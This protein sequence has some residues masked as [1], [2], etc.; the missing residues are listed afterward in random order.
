MSLELGTKLAGLRIRD[1]PFEQYLLVALSRHML[2]ATHLEPT[3]QRLT[4]VLPA[5]LRDQRKELRHQTQEVK[6]FI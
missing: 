1:L 2:E 3:G 6:I 5:V 4:E